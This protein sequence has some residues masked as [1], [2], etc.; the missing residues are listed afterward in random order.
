MTSVTINNINTQTRNLYKSSDLSLCAY[1]M[2]F[3]PVISV[4]NFGTGRVYF[5]FERSE[6]LKL[7]I[8]MFWDGSTTVVP[9]VYFNN[10]KTAKSRIFSM[11]GVL[12]WRQ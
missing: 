7:A 4:E 8:K 1:L 10:I 11:G 2:M 9:K 6:E 5:F 12:Q 3:F